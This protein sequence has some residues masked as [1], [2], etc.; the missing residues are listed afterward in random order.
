MT[1]INT[2]L[3]TPLGYVM[4]LCYR[5]LGNYGLAIIFFTLLTKVIMFPLSLIS[6][7]NSI[8]MVRMRPALDDIKQRYAGSGAEIAAE[9][10][11]LYRQEGYSTLKGMLPLLVQIPIILG[12]IN[13]IY[14]PMQHLLRLEP[15]TI[16]SLVARGA[17]LLNT[18]VA[19]LGTGAQ[20]RVMELVQAQPEQFRGIA[21]VAEIV[22]MDL[23]FLGL[24]LAQV[25]SFANL[26]WLYPVLSG[27]S[28]LALGFYQNRHNVLQR[29]QSLLS[30]WGMTIFLV[31]FSAFFAALLPI[32][33]GLYWIAG[34]LLSIPVLTLCNRIY[35]PRAALAEIDRLQPH[36]R[37]TREERRAERALRARQRRRQRADRKRFNAVPDKQLVFYSE[38]S[39]F[40]KYFFGFIDYVLA[41]SDLTVHY[42]TSDIDDQV[43]AMDNPRLQTYYIGPMALIQFMMLMDADMVVMTLPDLE[44]YHIKRS[45]VRKDIEYV[46][47]DHGMTSFHMMLKE[48]SLDHFDTIFCYGPNHIGEVRET[49]RVY[50]LP[51]KRLVKT[52]FPLL[53]QMIASVEAAGEIHNEPKKIL[54]APS[55]QKDNILEY[56]LDETLEPLLGLGYE[57]I[58]R[59]HPE[60]IKRF[61]AKM[62]AIL[63]RYGE[64]TGEHFRIETDFSS[65]ATVY[66]ADLVITDWSSIANE[67]SYATKKPS[68]FINTPMKVINPNY[69]KIPLV[70]L[71][72]ALRDEIGV[73][74]D[75][76]ELTRLPEIVAE[77]FAKR[78]WYRSHITEL[79]AR[80]IY[81]IGDGA[82]GGGEY[83]VRRLAERAR[84]RA[85]EQDPA[86]AAELV[87]AEQARE[88]E[89]ALALF[90]ELA[91]HVAQLAARR[92]T[93]REE[94]AAVLSQPLYDDSTEAR[95]T[96]AFVLDVLK[97]IAIDEEVRDEDA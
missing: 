36:T 76:E 60:F 22:D 42:V 43:F 82:R 74:V 85:A 92:E 63:E 46:Y 18:S 89:E 8:V 28:A 50:G 4:Y 6:Q 71:D 78:E 52:G 66:E 40:Y 44:T 94:I 55:W 62:Q 80:T 88:Q 51:P 67:Y 12:L 30:Q 64:R 11:A 5:L 33:V 84:Q 39:G 41:H 81:D 23:S 87:A 75:V 68:L 7:K 59:P 95:P 10:K 19:E 90:D 16:Y 15:E 1:L 31:A 35:D 61:P 65:S 9:Q 83:I 48:N 34:N 2:L 32:G 91:A 93:H 14:N 79:V 97:R 70:P 26:S 3:G 24:S 57:V 37:K 45:L 29:A 25:P 69:E 72:L 13:V 96:G 86:L 20:L 77:L 49:E 58:V 54:V 38:S 47:T 21:G 17:T 53:D 56:C 27:L 73:S